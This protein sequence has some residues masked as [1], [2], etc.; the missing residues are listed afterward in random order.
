MTDKGIFSPLLRSIYQ[1]VTGTSVQ[2]V[3]MFKKPLSLV[4]GIEY[5]V[6]LSFTFYRKYFLISGTTT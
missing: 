3:S 6:L 1:S 5:R 4:R 2:K